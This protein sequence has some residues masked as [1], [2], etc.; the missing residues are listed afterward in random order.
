LR[1]LLQADRIVR[2]N[3]L[4]VASFDGFPVTKRHTLVILRR[5]FAGAFGL[6]GDELFCSRRVWPRR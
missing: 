4:P 6:Q 1:L 5:Y 3:E 2:Q